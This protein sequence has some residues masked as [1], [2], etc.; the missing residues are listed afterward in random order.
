MRIT[1][2]GAYQMK[3]KRVGFGYFQLFINIIT[4]VIAFGSS[5]C[6]SFV[7]TPYL[8]T[9][10]GKEVYS[11]FPL[12]NNFVNYM[13]IIIIALN[14]MAARFISIEIFKNNNMRA[15]EYISSIFIS[16][17]F[18]SV[19]LLF[20]AILIVYYLDDL[21]NIPIESLWDVK[22]LFGLV[23][24]SM[25]INTLSSVFGVSV[26]TKNRL[27]L[28]AYKDIVQGL[29]KVI[30]LLILFLIYPP[31]IIYLGIV[32]VGLSFTNFLVDYIFTKKLFSTY[33]ISFSYFRYNLVKEV[34]I[35]GVW[36][37]VNS[38]GSILLL[39]MS[40]FL[41]NILI[42]PDASGELSIVQT[43]SSFMCGIIVLIYS[44][45]LPRMTEKYANGSSIN[46]GK[47]VR[48]SQKILSYFAT[49]PILL[50]LLFGNDFY[51]LWMPTENSDDLQ[52]LSII[53]M[54]PLLVHGNM[55]TIYGLNVTLNKQKKPSI[56]LILFGV[57][58]IVL[59]Y[60]DHV[61]FEG[62]L[63]SLISI[64][65]AVSV[66]YYLFYIPLY[67]AR[68]LQIGKFYFYSHML[69][70][71]LFCI[72]GVVFGVVIKHSLSIHSWGEFFYYNI[73]IGCMLLV[74]HMF[75]TLN[76]DEKKQL[77]YLLKSKIR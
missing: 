25:I 61:L 37:S 58:N 21:L 55:W 59:V 18:L 72:G 4:N 65:S 70:T 63:I 77:V 66:A 47:E 46:L 6:I 5:L 52:C 57:L 54:I 42:G 29:L 27:D 35:S 67:A 68:E 36:N 33:T 51:S 45:F 11:F 53:S 32:A 23:F 39:G 69:K 7:L 44:T 43:L 40:L 19:F 38:L 12:A 2:L 50:I 20:P 73:L 41:A 8:I 71:F 9:H 75:L 1:Q 14:S 17:V 62:D 24:L 30:L 26:F 64:S 15:Q 49:T 22:L 76:R 48:L 74:T 34:L 10:L 60:L 13:S 31:S 16:N 56:V 28:K 3:N